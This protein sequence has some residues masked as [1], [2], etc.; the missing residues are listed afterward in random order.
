MDESQLLIQLVT[1]LDTGIAAY[2]ANPYNTRPVPAGLTSAR[3]FQP[4]QQGAELTPTIYVNWAGSV[5]RGYPKRQ[6]KY[7]ADTGL[8]MHIQGQRMESTY[9]IEALIPQSPA[10]PDAMTESDVLDVARFILQNDATI[11]TLRPLNV[12]LLR[13]TQIN[14]QY[15]VDDREQNENVPF[16]EIVFSHRKEVTLTAPTID[17]FNTVFARV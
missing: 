10:D 1:L 4:R 5:P 13:V 12:G 15:I 17:T 2:I 16:F 14:S 3:A 8:M 7:D 6:S 11:E 9:H